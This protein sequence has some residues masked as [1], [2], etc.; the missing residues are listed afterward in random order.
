MGQILFAQ[1]RTRDE[2][3]IWASRLTPARPA[4]HAASERQRYLCH[5]MPS[6]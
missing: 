1:R 3:V 2:R 5:V 6:A 4:M